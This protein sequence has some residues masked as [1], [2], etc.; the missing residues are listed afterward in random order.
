M[1]TTHFSIVITCFNQSGF[2]GS[3]I[4]S[5]LLQ[6][7]PAAE[8][9]VVDDASTDGSRELIRSFADSI[10]LIELAVN[11][12]AV[13]ARNLGAET[14]TGEYLV[15]LDGDD[16]LVPWA[17]EI[18]GQLIT[19]RGPKLIFARQ[20]WFHGDVPLLKEEESPVKVEFFEFDDLISKDR[21]IGLSA[22]AFVV[23]REAFEGVG[24]WTSGV[25]H[26]DLVDIC[27]KLGRTGRTVL[28]DS[29]PTVLYRVHSSNSIK[30]VLPF[31]RMSHEIIHKARNGQ[32]SATKAN[33]FKTD[34]WLGGVMVFW[35]R[36]AI[37]TKLYW[38]ALKL[39][40]DA[41]PM[42]VAATTRRLVA[43][44]RGRVP[45]QT[46]DLDRVAGCLTSG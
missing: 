23:L 4:R 18:Y 16:L 8:I 5:A 29:P 34:A 43:V 27:T 37:A 38:E 41:L 11:R 6:S 12:G 35:I 26:L 1:P 21:P 24:G 17:L 42:I 14:A 20:H 46:S 31:L 45:L 9:I 2:I 40:S 7:L 36:R 22:S 44:V 19:A 32:Y 10:R 33:R 15:F 13:E 30:N 39:L 25:F 28:I 3:A